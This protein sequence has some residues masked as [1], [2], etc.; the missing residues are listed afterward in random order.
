MDN[1]PMENIQEVLKKPRGRPRLDPKPEIEENK[2][3][4]PRGRPK[5]QPE[6]LK[7]KG[8]TKDE[9]YFKK[10][11]LEKTKPKLDEIKINN[12]CVHCGKCIKE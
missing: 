7:P 8:K 1:Q 11:Y 6:Q 9:N 12:K 5:L 3:P 2:Q 10:Y 4:K